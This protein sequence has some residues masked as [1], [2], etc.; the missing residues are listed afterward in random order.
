[1]E[2]R[3]HPMSL[4]EIA[5][6][7]RSAAWNGNIRISSHALLRF[8]QRIKKEGY[9]LH[10]A[11]LIEALKK[12]AYIVGVHRAENKYGQLTTRYMVMTTVNMRDVQLVMAYSKHCYSIVTVYTDGKGIL[13]GGQILANIEEEARKRRR[14]E[15]SE[16]IRINGKQH[17]K[18]KKKSKPKFDRYMDQLASLT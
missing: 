11:E 15:A 14:R 6:R 9:A 2:V 13:F 16:E 12:E 3:Y 1:M 17:A 8:N 18:K 4:T 10:E 5:K 7:I